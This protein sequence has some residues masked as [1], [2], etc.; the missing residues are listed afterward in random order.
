MN[1]HP[2]LGESYDRIDTPA[3]LVDY[4]ILKRNIERVQK[5]HDEVGLQMRP[6]IKAHKTPEIA[7]MQIQAGAIGVTCA[8]IAEAEVMAT[9]GIEDIFI[10]NCIVGRPKMRRL[11]ALA[12]RVPK[13]SVAVESTEAAREL[14]NAF[15]NA[16]MTC[17]VI[18]ELDTG[19][20]RAGV[21]P[22]RAVDF[23][24]ALEAFSAL[25]LKGIM[26]YAGAAYKKRG[27]EGFR[28]A[29]R[30]ETRVMGQIADEIRSAGYALEV[31]SGGCTPT[32]GRYEEKGGLTEVR[33]GTY[34]LNDHNQVDMGA[35][36]REDVAA[37]VLSTVVAIPAPERAILDAGTKSLAQQVSPIT[38][39]FGWLVDKECGNIHKTNDEHG[40]LNL[41]R[42]EA[43]VEV[44]EKLR[45][46]PPRICT[47][48]NLYD[49]LY[50][51]KD[52]MIRDIW[53]I[54]ARG[55]NT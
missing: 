14:H 30:E 37:T 11:V 8:K 27:D 49:Y 43:T 1:T 7:H 22:E 20:G 38:E 40:F 36:S 29:A 41:T 53:R 52:G 55:A 33:P 51:I 46:I 18:I 48:L 28:E 15:D 39:G 45:I 34:C 32:A 17:D 6:H 12:K 54:E 47:C 25:T 13:L 10:A 3:L 24:G 50:V 35:C 19:A 42:M 31:V 26:A 5:A 4:R 23:A 44:G 21:L 2:L 16:G 9:A